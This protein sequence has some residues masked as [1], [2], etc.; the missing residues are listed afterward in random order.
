MGGRGDRTGSVYQEGR[1]APASALVSVLALPSPLWTLSRSNPH[2]VKTGR[3]S[4]ASGDMVGGVSRAPARGL[5]FLTSRF[6]AAAGPG[7]DCLKSC[8]TSPHPNPSRKPL[9]SFPSCPRLGL[10]IAQVSQRRARVRRAL[11]TEADSR[12]DCAAKNMDRSGFETGPGTLAL[13]GSDS[14]LRFPIVTAN[15]RAQCL[16][17]RIS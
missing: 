16:R 17:T 2:P 4:K 14:S 8:L 10:A 1:Q 12:G 7:S 13:L 5:A 15:G 11:Q 6:L 9:S 3:V